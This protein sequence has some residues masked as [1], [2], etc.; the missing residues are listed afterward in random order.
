MPWLTLTA[1]KGFN[2]GWAWPCLFNVHQERYDFD[3]MVPFPWQVKELQAVEEKCRLYVAATKLDLLDGQKKRQ[4]WRSIFLE[5]NRS[6]A[7]TFSGR[8]SQHNR[9]LRCQRCQTV[10]DLEQAE[11]WHW[12]TVRHH[13][14]RL[15]GRCEEE[16]KHFGA[17]DGKQDQWDRLGKEGK[18]E[19]LL[20]FKLALSLRNV[21]I[22]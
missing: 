21:K 4:V 16:P 5:I 8:L 12:G 10:W 22:C 20:C 13:C 7:F 3:L 2:F 1:G 14:R 18:E 15:C 17:A 9:L 11:R 19:S 6:R